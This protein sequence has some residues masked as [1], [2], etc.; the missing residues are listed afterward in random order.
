MANAPEWVDPFSPQGTR[1]ATAKILTGRNY[2]LFYEDATRRTL[3]ETYRSLTELAR[4]YPQDSDAWQTHVRELVSTGD[5]EDRRMRQWLI[6]LT[7]KTA[8]NLGVKVG[9]Y[10]S[11]FD[12][13]M[14]DIEA[15]A[16]SDSERREI[17]LLLWCG[18]ATLTIRGSQKSK[19]GKS[20]EVAIARAA[21]LS[22]GLSE[23]TGDFRLNV[24]AD[25][26]VDR[27][28]DCEIRTP[29][30]FVRMEVG[31]IG[32][33]NPEVIGDKVGRMDRNG[34][35]LMDYLPAR[36]SAY[37]TAEHRGVRLIQLRNN[38][39]VEE[40]RQHLARLQVPV[41]EDAISPEEVERRVLVMPDAVF[42]RSE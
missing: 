12:D 27:E 22:I 5:L 41:Q 7:M 19:I 40:L 35:I 9:D 30:G 18:T 37:R 34:I 8:Q 2:R 39:P 14:A 38:H 25:R 29:R 23:E 17:A 26:E 36:S 15:V 21:L 16:S 32:Q 42:V 31:L 33:G 24:G 11:V 28:T 10:S 4:M 3:I 6:G 20:L 13:M 1:E